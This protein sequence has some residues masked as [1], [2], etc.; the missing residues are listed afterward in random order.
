MQEDVH[1]G[2]D[3]FPHFTIIERYRT[4]LGSILDLRSH[5]L[6]EMTRGTTPVPCA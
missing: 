3:R 4:E 6:N 5:Q 2:S 1:A